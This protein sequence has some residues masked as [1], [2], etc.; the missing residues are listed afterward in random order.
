MAVVVIC[1]LT[2][3]VVSPQFR[4]LVKGIV[5]GRITGVRY[6]T[7]LRAPL[8]APLE[9]QARAYKAYRS[10]CV[11]AQ[12]PRNM[13]KFRYEPGDLLAFDN[14]RALHGRSGYAAATGKRFI[15]GMYTDRDDLYS[16]IRILNRQLS[17]AAAS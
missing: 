17:A 10:F 4:T 11:R 2:A 3:C 12:D 9:I 14:R 16:R 5:R 13:M 6:N 15:E 1:S 8:K 7:F